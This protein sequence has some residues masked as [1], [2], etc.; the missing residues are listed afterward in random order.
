MERR[1]TRKKFFSKPPPPPPPQKEKCKGASVRA[2]AFSLVAWNISSQ[3]SWSPFHSPCWGKLNVPTLEPHPPSQKCALPCRGTLNIP[4]CK[5]HVCSWEHVFPCWK[6]LGIDGNWWCIG[7]THF[8]VGSSNVPQEHIPLWEFTFP[9]WGT[10]NVLNWEP[11][12]LSWEFMSH[13]WGTLN[14][15]IGECVIFTCKYL[16]C[17]FHTRMCVLTCSQTSGICVSTFHIIR[18]RVVANKKEFLNWNHWFFPKKI[19]N[20]ELGLEVIC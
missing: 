16:F 13:S 10:L 12:V 14:C 4:T 15:S 3:K 20:L 19:K 17:Y 9:S 5:S 8:Y 1:K 7:N 6:T 11:H 18:L 2:W